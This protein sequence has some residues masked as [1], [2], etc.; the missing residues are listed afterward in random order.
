MQ[1]GMSFGAT[2]NGET[3]RR[4]YPRVQ[5]SE[6][7]LMLSD[8]I[9]ELILASHILKARLFWESI[10]YEFEFSH[11]RRGRSRAIALSL[12]DRERGDRNDILMFS[13][14]LSPRIC[15]LPFS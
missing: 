6:S 14:L 2:A 9:Y 4:L 10:L 1:Q 3:N 13:L 15:A 5:N 11:L 12:R 7:V 8:L